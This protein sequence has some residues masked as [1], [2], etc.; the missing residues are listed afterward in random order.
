MCDVWCWRG[1]VSLV[2]W[3]CDMCEPLWEERAGLTCLR[4]MFPWSCPQS[5]D[6]NINTTGVRIEIFVWT[7]HSQ[8]WNIAFKLHLQNYLSEPDWTVFRFLLCW[9][10]TWQSGL[11]GCWK[12]TSLERKVLGWW[13]YRW[14]RSITTKG[15]SLSPPW[16]GRG[17]NTI[18]CWRGRKVVMVPWQ[19]KN[20]T[21]HY[22]R[23]Y[24]ERNIGEGQSTLWGR[25]NS[26]TDWEQISN[27][28]NVCLNILVWLP[29]A[30]KSS[31]MK[32]INTFK[33]FL[34]Y[35]LSI[36]YR[37]SHKDVLFYYFDI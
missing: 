18:Q 25:I 14:D 10:T 36:N 16:H 24:T 21:L 13:D 4:H 23:S 2:R 33:I 20:E 30:E 22:C 32:F 3:Y 28:K 37:T 27:N 17:R 7:S 15:V 35:P 11:T 19:M 34:Y 5:P 1:G 9:R 29:Q 31:F 26:L 12:E 8:M 6:V